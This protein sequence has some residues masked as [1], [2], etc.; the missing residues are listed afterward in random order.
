[1]TIKRKRNPK[2]K[3]KSKKKRRWNRWKMSH[4]IYEHISLNFNNKTLKTHFK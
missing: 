1:M 2:K 4:M 3:E